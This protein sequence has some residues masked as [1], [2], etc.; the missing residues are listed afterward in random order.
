MTPGPRTHAGASL[1]IARPKALPKHMQGPILEVRDF[2]TREEERGKGQAGILMLQTT[3]EADLAGVMLFLCVDPEDERTRRDQL[4]A[5]YARNGF[6]PIQTEPKVL[7][8]RPHVN[9]I[10][11]AKNG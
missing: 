5:F 1:T 6:M 11:G 10:A 7:M 3:M 9:M 8:V 2:R 4:I